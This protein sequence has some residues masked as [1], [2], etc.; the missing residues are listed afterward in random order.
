MGQRTSSI[1]FSVRCP[2]G[3]P[4]WKRTGLQKK[5]D[6]CSHWHAHAHLPTREIV[7]RYANKTPRR[8]TQRHMG[9]QMGTTV[10][11]IANKNYNLKSRDPS[12]LT[13]QKR[14]KLLS[15]FHNKSKI[16]IYSCNRYYNHIIT[17][18]MICLEL[19]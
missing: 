18:S 15:S 10:N 14:H 7:R 16:Q 4:V 5:T 9:E 8:G 11:S 17:S 13:M 2:F 12:G 1:L 19:M 6:V 3:T